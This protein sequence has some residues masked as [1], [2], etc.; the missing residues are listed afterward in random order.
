MNY[1]ISKTLKSNIEK[2]S[3]KKGITKTKIANAFAGT[4]VFSPGSV[5]SSAAKGWDNGIIPSEDRLNRISKVLGENKEILLGFTPSQDK[6]IESA[7]R[8]HAPKEDAE[9]KV[10]TVLRIC[11]WLGFTV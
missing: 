6:S 9:S 11:K 8:A 10:S 7:L 1:K 4:K 5:Y 2:F 3:I